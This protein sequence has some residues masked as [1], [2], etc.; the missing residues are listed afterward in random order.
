[1]AEELPDAP[2]AEVDEPGELLP[3]LEPLL[4][5]DW[6]MAAPPMP[7]AKLAAIAS[8]VRFINNS[9]WVRSIEDRPVDVHA[10]G[11]LVGRSQRGGV[12]FAPTS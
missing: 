4:P 1:M 10:W 6:A 2:L 11:S 7:R 9:F 3:P 12:R 5:D 8:R